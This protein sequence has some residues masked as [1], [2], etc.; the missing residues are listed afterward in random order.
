MAE[1]AAS[2][3]ERPTAVQT[4][5]RFFEDRHIDAQMRALIPR[6]ARLAVA[7]TIV[8]APVLASDTA[9]TALVVGNALVALG[10]TELVWRTGLLERAQP[11]HVYTLL[12]LFVAQI[13]FGGAASE[14]LLAYSFLQALPIVFAAAFF[15]SPVAR[16]SLPF[17]A[18]ATEYVAMI[19]YGELPLRIAVVRLLCLLLVALF[20]VALANVLREAL[21]THHSLHAV[22]EAS[23]ESVDEQT[24][25]RRGLDAALS[26]VAWDAGAVALVDQEDGDAV[27]IEAISGVSNAVAEHYVGVA[28]HRSDAGF[29]WQVL[30]SRRLTEERA[31]G[32]ILPP[33]HPMAQDGFTA[34]AGTPIHYHG[35]P[36]GVLLTFDRGSRALDDRERDRLTGVAEQL[37]LALGSARAHRREAEVAASL[38]E[39]NRRKDAFLAAVS[40]ELR[41]PATTIE[42]AS[43]TLQRADDRL[44]AEERAKVR[45]ALVSRSRELRELIEALLDVALTES[46][47]SRLLLEPVRWGSTVKRW[48]ADMEERL[49]RPIE[50]FV[51]G[52]DFESNA[53]PAKMERVLFALVSNAVKFSM[54]DT[55]VRV[56]LGVDATSVTLAVSDE[57]MGILP[58]DVERIFDR[59]LQLDDSTTREVGGLG[60]GLTLVRH[61]VGLH[62]G[63]VHVESDV[64][65]G[66]TFTV[67]IPR[68]CEPRS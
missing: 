24:L 9:R 26:V 10:V 54:P 51:P 40:H 19:P 48:V 52:E 43:R 30:R 53:D 67:T 20:G 62:G 11:W 32:R 41:T 6:F 21:R 1:A 5:I 45:N 29:T 44:S 61:F 57:G 38:R 12:S 42:L 36:I 28:L 3:T 14:H 37:G 47:E 34:M 13:S 8:T 25:A 16:Y 68:L 15:D 59:F 63:R 33:D 50:L 56:E 23:T 4:S 49:G 55:E 66:S 27:T 60:I 7:L 22:L 39:L 18:T 35:E 31:I 64:G 46:G 58:G 65:K 2:G 17:L